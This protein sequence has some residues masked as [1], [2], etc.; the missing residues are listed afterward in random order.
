MDETSSENIIHGPDSGAKVFFHKHVGNCHVHI[1]QKNKLDDL[2]I[3]FHVSN[4]TVTIGDDNH[5]RGH[6][7]FKKLG[8]SV[9]IGQNNKMITGIFMNVGGP[10]MIGNRCLFSN[11]KFRSTD[12]HYIFDIQTGDQI[13]PDAPITIGDDVWLAEDVML[14]G[15]SSVGNGSVIG[16]RALVTGEILENCLAAGIPAKTIR[17]GVRWKE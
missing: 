2:H 3:H 5:I 9:N 16:S 7:F 14:F 10:I 11:A 1:G 12:S 13:N 6:I 17:R 15:G 4:C 8:G